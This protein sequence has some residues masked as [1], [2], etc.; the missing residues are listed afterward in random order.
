MS[1]SRRWVVVV[2]GLSG[3]GKASV[4]RALEDLGFAAVD[5]PPLG[6]VPALVRFAQ[7]S[8]AVGVDARTA[9]FDAEE[10]VR[11]VQHLR[12]DPGIAVEMI[13]CRADEA[14]LLRRYSE[15]RRRHPLAPEGRVAEG[16]AQEQE[17]TEPLYEAADLPLDTSALPLAAMRTIIEGRYGGEAGD[18][19]PRMAVTLISFSYAHGLPAEADLVFDTRFLRNPH[20]DPIL[21][22]K[23]GQDP[24]VAAYVEAD[25]DYAAF[26][27]GVE[28]LLDLLL[29][30][31][32]AEGKKYATVAAG[33]TG[34]RHR[35][36]HLIE[37]LAAY[38]AEMRQTSY[39][40]L[41]WRV[42]VR[43]RE[44]ARQGQSTDPEPS[45]TGGLSNSVLNI[46]NI[47]HGEGKPFAS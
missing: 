42:H 31:F 18:A 45:G 43:H 26:E 46:K 34:G 27:G 41:P 9:G 23:T 16:I 4:L 14:T 47:G 15:T 21:R 13:Y 44:L 30:R 10:V 5:N 32:L 3:A 25:P 40:P 19:S 17:L 33:C 22:P 12:T 37:K 7:G 20:Y 1:A 36:V 29:P 38:L 39:E 11:A 6:M 35:S 24:D 8:I 2:T 28:R